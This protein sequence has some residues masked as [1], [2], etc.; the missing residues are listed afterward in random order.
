MSQGI[1]KSTMI[2]L[3][4]VTILLS[5]L[6]NSMVVVH[7]RFTG[8]LRIHN[9][10]VW[11]EDPRSPGVVVL[12]TRRNTTANITID[13]TPRIVL[14]R[15][16]AVYFDTFDTNP[17]TARRLEVIN[18]TWLYDST[19]GTINISATEASGV[20]FDRWCIVT[21]SSGVAPWETYRR[22]GRTIYVSAVL[23]R[24]IFNITATSVIRLDVIYFASGVPVF[25]AFGYN[26]TLITV[27]TGDNLTSTLTYRVYAVPGT[28]H[29]SHRYMGISNITE[30]LFLY[31]VSAGFNYTSWE[32]VHFVNE[33]FIHRVILPENLRYAY[34]YAPG[35]GYR[36]TGGITGGMIMFDSLIVTLDYPPWFINITN[37]PENWLVVLR[38][39]TGH[40]VSSARSISGVAVL[41]AYPNLTDMSVYLYNLSTDPGFIYRNATFEVYDDSGRL[42]VRRRFDVVLGGDLYVFDPPLTILSVYSNLSTRFISKL[43]LA[44]PSIYMCG[45]EFNASIGLVNRTLASTNPFIRIVNGVV[46][47]YETGLI[48]A[49]P[50]ATWTGK[51][52]ALN[53]T[54]TFRLLSDVPYCSMTLRYIW[55]VHNGTLVIYHIYLNLTRT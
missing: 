46:V 38:N 23:M 33:T 35:L 27:R 13:A 28:V 18:C 29:I 42:I 41:R 51:W 19:R 1:S 17:F 47:D 4:L 10:V 2:A 3:L 49:Y 39:S 52:L 54:G 30:G 7:R 34:L 50:P 16:S 48:E 9:P 25:Y 14:E 55:W 44:S 22:E 40:V 5:A 36:W 6:V 11:F 15:R 53:V 24:N 32:V 21:V 20:A 8:V 37:L 31:H 12:L 26:N 43:E 45:P